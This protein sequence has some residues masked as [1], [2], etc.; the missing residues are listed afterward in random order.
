MAEYVKNMGIPKCWTC[1]LEWRQRKTTAK[2]WLGMT[3]TAYKDHWV[4]VCKGRVNNNDSLEITD[5]AT[6]DLWNEHATPG[7]SPEKEFYAKYPIKKDVP[8]KY[9]VTPLHN[10]C[11]GLIRK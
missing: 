7:I 8:L 4:V 11:N 9:N 6:F 1:R 10:T 3:K 5:V 2:N